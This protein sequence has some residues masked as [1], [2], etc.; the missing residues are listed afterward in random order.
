MKKSVIIKFEIDGFHFYENAPIEVS[1]LQYLHRHT[2]IIS[3]GFNVT[4]L[5]REKEIFIERQRIKNYLI[6]KFGLPCYFYEM[7][8]EMIAN[9]ILE[10]FQKDNMQ[11]CEVWEE[12]TGGSKIEI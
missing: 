9:N 2:F 10:E 5:N 6:E 11:W 1:F 12:N 4:D 8:C 3:A 7:S